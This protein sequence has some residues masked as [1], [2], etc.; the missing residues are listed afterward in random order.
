MKKVISIRAPFTLCRRVC[1][2]LYCEQEKNRGRGPEREREKERG[3]E[4]QAVQL[5]ES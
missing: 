2:C 5:G 3:E 1:C 4:K